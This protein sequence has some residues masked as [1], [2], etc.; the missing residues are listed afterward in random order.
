M[1]DIAGPIVY[2]V[3]IWWASTG[4]IVYLDGLPRRTFRLS[5]GAATA[6]AAL[7]LW[8]GASSADMASRAGAWCGFTVGLLAWGWVELTFLTGVLTGPWRRPCPAGARGL[9]R[10]GYAIAAILWHELAIIVMAVLLAFTTLGHANDTA[11][12]TFAILW[13]MRS[14]AKLNVFL[15]VRN[16]A[17]EF[18]PPHLKYLASFFRQ[19]PMN[20]LFPVSVTGGTIAAVLLFAAAAAPDASAFA[21]TRL[22]LLGTL[23]ALAVIEHWMLVLPI[24]PTALWQWSLRRRAP[25]LSSAAS[26]A[27]AATP[28]KGA[29]A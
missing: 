25:A 12:W 27:P 19:R 15:G 10:A 21:T 17:E 6:I 20:F 9:S 4:L 13:I 1:T 7:A 3:A 28:V 8:G 26:P 16:L 29:P 23:L 14:S 5:V 24:S 11:F 2:A 22:S 18:L